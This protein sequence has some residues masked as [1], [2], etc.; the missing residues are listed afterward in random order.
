MINFCLSICSCV[1]WALPKVCKKSSWNL[2]ER[3]IHC[4]LWKY[5]CWLNWWKTCKIVQAIPAQ[6]MPL[7]ILLPQGQK[8]ITGVSWPAGTQEQLVQEKQRAITVASPG[9]QATLSAGLPVSLIHLRERKSFLYVL[10]DLAVWSSVLQIAGM[11]LPFWMHRDG[12][13]SFLQIFDSS[14]TI[15]VIQHYWNKIGISQMFP[16]ERL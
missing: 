5:T 12:R 15:E 14:P 11:V 2:D 9:L 4:D 7:L 1:L 16:W 8:N 10:T 13:K 6:K 3:D